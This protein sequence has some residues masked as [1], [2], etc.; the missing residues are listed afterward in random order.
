MTDNR[1]LDEFAAPT[2]QAEDPADDV[3][4][5]GS[6]PLD[7][8][9]SSVADDPSAADG[10]E[11]DAEPADEPIDPIASTYAWSPAGGECSA[12]GSTVEERWRDGDDLVCLDCKEW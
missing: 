12:C 2:G 6:G 4:T 7:A 11:S 3:E 5:S 9:A 10:D 8:D 1:S